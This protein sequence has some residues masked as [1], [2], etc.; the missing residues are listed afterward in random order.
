MDTRDVLIVEILIGFVVTALVTVFYGVV[1]PWYKQSAGRYIFALLLALSLVLTNTIVRV[2]FPTFDN[3][4]LF[5]IIL[6]GFYIFAIGSIGIGV[7][8]AQIGHWK[9]KRFIREEKERH[10]Q[11]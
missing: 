4:R 10:R 6:F 3:G 5:G 9:K 11:L 2:F 1:A 7:Y 8:K